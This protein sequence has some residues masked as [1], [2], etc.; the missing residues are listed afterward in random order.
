MVCSPYYS[1]SNRRG[2]PSLSWCQQLSATLRSRYVP[3]PPGATAQLKPATAGF[4]TNFPLP[5]TLLTKPYSAPLPHSQSPQRFSD[6]FTTTFPGHQRSFGFLRA[7]K[8][9]VSSVAEFNLEEHLSLADV[10]VDSHF[11]PSMLR[12]RIKQ[13]RS[14]WVFWQGTPSALPGF[15][16]TSQC[17]SQSKVVNQALSSSLQMAHSSPGSGWWTRSGL[18]KGSYAGHSFRICA[19]A[20]RGVEDSLIQNLGRW[21]SSA[22][23]RYIRISRSLLASVSQLLAA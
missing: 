16:S 10:A 3:P 2:W 18:N 22:Y 13:Y 12:V 14:A 1:T 17:T 23:L 5:H 21:H 6:K 8:F 4:A 11:S 15:R 20:A 7:G 19:A 9:T